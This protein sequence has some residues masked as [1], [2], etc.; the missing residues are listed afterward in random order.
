MSFFYQIKLVLTIL[1]LNLIFKIIY[2][3]L[4]Q[5]NLIKITPILSMRKYY[6]SHVSIAKNLQYRLDFH[7][8]IH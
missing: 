5:I 8:A 1:I 6:L 3:I 7:L 2:L 4:D